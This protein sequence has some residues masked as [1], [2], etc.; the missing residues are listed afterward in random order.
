[1]PDVPAD[2]QLRMSGLASDALSMFRL[3]AYFDVLS[4]SAANADAL[5]RSAAL[6]AECPVGARWASGTVIRYGALG[7]PL[8]ESF[9]P[10][11]KSAEPAVW[12][13]R[14]AD[15]EHP[16][17]SLLLD[18]LQ[19]TL[20][21]AA[22]RSGGGPR[23]GHP[24][25]LE[26]VLSDKERR[27]D[28]VRAV[29]LLGLDTSREVR[30]LA[31]SAA[32]SKAA[33]D[34]VARSCPGRL[35][36]SVEVGN[37]TAVLLQDDSDDG[38]LAEGL[39]A[40]IVAEHPMALSGT[41]GLRGPWVG[42][43]GRMSVYAAPASWKQARRAL[44]FASS[45]RYG[46]RAVSYGALGSLELLA[47]LPLKRLLNDPDAA[48]INA[49]ATSPG[50]EQE[51]ATLEAYCVF[52]SL[53]RTAEEMHVH[54]STVA[55]RLAHLEAEMGWDLADPMDRFKAT[56]VLMVRRVTLS[57]TELASSAVF[58]ETF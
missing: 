18:R 19:H 27:E 43:G 45:T 30:A 34:L 54:H 41:G 57:S 7:D 36:H 11:P 33:L 9:P 21:V 37:L 10:T 4:E 35:V 28:R 22:P 42:I 1:M 12:L 3:I 51:V 50:G 25:L 20:R 6:L 52:G 40:A 26:V 48:R 8:D 29:G 15:A 38:E 13:E 2:E 24:A 55:A 44:R 39:H 58:G 56:L 49:I 31:V 53:R 14:A 47:E 5:V 17:D 32:S 23:L 46:R 16:L